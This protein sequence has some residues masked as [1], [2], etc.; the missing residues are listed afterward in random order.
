MLVCDISYFSDSE[1]SGVAGLSSLPLFNN[2]LFSG[3]NGDKAVGFIYSCYLGIRSSG[4]IFT[5]VPLNKPD[6][7]L[8]EDKE[9]VTEAVSLNFLRTASSSGAGASAL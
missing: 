7:P 4:V 2:I 6:S 5:L 8:D 3:R 1:V 9:D